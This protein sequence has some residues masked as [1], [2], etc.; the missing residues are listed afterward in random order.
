MTVISVLGW[1]GLILLFETQPPSLPLS[2]VTNPIWRTFCQM[3]MMVTEIIV[4]DK[5]MIHVSEPID[6]IWQPEAASLPRYSTVDVCC[7]GAE[8]REYWLNIVTID[9]FQTWYWLNITP[10]NISDIGPYHFFL[11]ICRLPH[12][13]WL[14]FRKDNEWRMVGF[15]QIG[16][17]FMIYQL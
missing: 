8:G 6:I 13:K 16:K 7:C 17:K 4:E 10:V 11:F 14:S 1:V 15:F 2:P 12:F 5:S 3:V 9:R